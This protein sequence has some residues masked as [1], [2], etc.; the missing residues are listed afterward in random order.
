MKNEKHF[1]LS[2]GQIPGPLFR[3]RVLSI[4][5]LTLFIAGYFWLLAQL[6]ASVI[7]LPALFALTLIVG[8]TLAAV[9]LVK[10][11][12]GMGDI[13]KSRML[14]FIP[15]F[16]VMYSLPAV[17]GH[18]NYVSVEVSGTETAARAA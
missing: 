13:R 5:G 3:K 2:T 4:T 18:L 16:G 7:I 1:C 11:L 9:Q 8:H 15:F 17:M 14:T 6:Y 10:C 12:N